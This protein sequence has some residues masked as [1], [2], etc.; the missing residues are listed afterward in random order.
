MSAG[1]YRIS[2]DLGNTYA[3]QA[4]H[5]TA[6]VYDFNEVAQLTAVPFVEF[7]AST[8]SYH[9]DQVIQA[10]WL[11]AT[12]VYTWTGTP[13]I[14]TFPTDTI[15]LVDLDLTQAIGNTQTQG[16]LGRALLASEVEGF[17]KWVISPDGLTL[18][19]YREDGVTVER[20]FTLNSAVAPTSRT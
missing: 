5:L 10:I 6:T 9:S 1:S 4:S 18:T 14:T 3:G 17:G 15:N 7:P 19:V 12:I 16:T 20:V 2:A 8:G 13:A 11:P